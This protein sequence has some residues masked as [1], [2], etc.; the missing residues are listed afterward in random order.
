MYYNYPT[1]SGF[2]MTL[3]ETMYVNWIHQSPETCFSSQLESHW[4]NNIEK[5]LL[6]DPSLSVVSLVSV[7]RNGVIHTQRQVI[8]NQRDAHIKMWPSLQTFFVA[9]N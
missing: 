9:D 6:S 7:R 3:E 2:N 4:Q 8:Y 5:L 1:E